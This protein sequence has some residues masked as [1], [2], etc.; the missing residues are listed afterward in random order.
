MSQSYSDGWHVIQKKWWNSC[1]Q[2]TATSLALYFFKII[3]EF[4]FVFCFSQRLRQCRLRMYIYET[5]WDFCFA[6]LYTRFLIT[7]LQIWKN[8]QWSSQISCRIQ[9][10]SNHIQLSCRESTK[11]TT[12]TCSI[13]VY[14]VLLVMSI[15]HVVW[16]CVS[17]WCR[18]LCNWFSSISWKVIPTIEFR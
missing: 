9:M 6:K 14:R 13:F 17:S 12:N 18:R 7:L 5:G 4:F 2:F 15:S 1:I 10:I 3:T 16:K 8:D 11:C